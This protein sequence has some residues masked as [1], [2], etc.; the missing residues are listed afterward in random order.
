[1]YFVSLLN[2][3]LDSVLETALNQEVR[4]SNSLLFLFYGFVCYRLVLGCLLVF[5]LEPGIHQ[6][7]LTQVG[8]QLTT[9]PA[10]TETRDTGFN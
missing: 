10:N 9:G 6:V 7:T 2:W 8:L 1:M 4:E 5:L 3:N